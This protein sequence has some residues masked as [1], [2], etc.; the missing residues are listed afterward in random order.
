MS[1]GRIF[2]QG[3]WWPLQPESIPALQATVASPWEEDVVEALR[4]WWNDA[5]VVITSTSGS[6]GN[7]RPIQHAKAAMEESAKRTLHHF[8]LMEGAT[9]GLAMPVKF[10]GGMMMLVRAVVGKLDLV[11][12]QPQACPDFGALPCSSLDFLPLTP[13]QA[14]AFHASDSS[15][16]A[17]IQ[18]LL[19][20]GGPV[21]RAWLGTLDGGPRI[22]ESFGMTETISH[23]AL[24][25]VHPNREEDFH[26]LPGFEVFSGEQEALVIDGP[27]GTRWETRDAAQVLSSRSFKWLGRLDGVINSGGIKI[28]PERVEWILSGFLTE[29]FKC[30]GK[31]DARWGEI[32]ILRIDSE[33]APPD[34]EAMRD[35]ILAWADDH[36]PKHHAPKM[37]EW[38]P[39]ERT[40]TGKWK[41]PHA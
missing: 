4:S 6:T 37:V 28:H 25:E 3:Q 19:L 11:A 2:L 36:L 7:P 5:E 16:W 23:F 29:P 30:Y 24:R 15:S 35:R 26:C 21:N 9:A 13:S 32:L 8:G 17:R 1:E 33:A 31:P 41:M 14:Q 34:A 12:V 39:L 40:W 18:C 20:G 10:I 22:V 27:D 38:A